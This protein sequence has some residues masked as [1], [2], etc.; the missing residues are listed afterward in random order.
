MGTLDLS[1]IG[2]LCPSGHKTNRARQDTLEELHPRVSHGISGSGSLYTSGASSLLPPS[3]DSYLFKVPKGK[4]TTRSWKNPTSYP[5]AVQPSEFDHWESHMALEGRMSCPV[6]ATTPAFLDPASQPTF[7]AKSCSSLSLAVQPSECPYP[8]SHMTLKGHTSCHVEATTLAGRPTLPI[9]S[10]TTM[11]SSILS[12]HGMVRPFLTL[13]QSKEKNY[14]LST[15]LPKLESPG[16]S[17]SAPPLSSCGKLDT[18]ESFPSRSID[19]ITLST[20]TSPTHGDLSITA[21]AAPPITGAKL[22]LIPLEHLL[23]VVPLP[24]SRHDKESLAR[25][26]L[27]SG[28]R[29]R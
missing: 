23:N 12:D 13:P 11:S 6:N 9:K 14:Y 21:S 20:L 1:D 10:S 3:Q 4:T 18:Q 24:R 25:L 27:Y 2:F 16:L 26:G 28:Q 5:L 7:L 17:S 19:P 29:G 8:E 15:H 22:E